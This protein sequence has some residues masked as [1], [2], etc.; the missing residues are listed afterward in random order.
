MCP[1]RCNPISLANH[2]L[3]W[4]FSG[5][6][7]VCQCRRHRFDPWV[8]KDPL[9]KEMGTYSIIL[10]WKTH[11]Q[12]RLAGCSPQGGRESDMTATKGQQSMITLVTFTCFKSHLYFHIDYLT[13]FPE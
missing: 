3:P 11:G 12:R 13:L 10:V 4:W 2:G 8:G 9:E 6:E 1:K 7:S 5:E